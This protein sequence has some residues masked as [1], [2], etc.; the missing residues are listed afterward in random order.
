M[1]QLAFGTRIVVDAR[2]VD[3]DSLNLTEGAAVLAAAWPLGGRVRRVQVGNDG[4]TLAFLGSQ[5]FM[6]LHTFPSQKRLSLVAFTVGEVSTA[7]FLAHA[8]QILE[9]KIYDL[10]RSRYGHGFPKD[11]ELLER[12]LLGERF[13]AYARVGL[14]LG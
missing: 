10:R 6:L 7:A 5:G 12:V 4:V 11:E 13:L 9:M 14:S 3:T 1:Q 8:E 2:D